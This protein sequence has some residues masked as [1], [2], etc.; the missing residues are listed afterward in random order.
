MRGKLTESNNDYSFILQNF[1]PETIMTILSNHCINS[2]ID[3]LSKNIFLLRD[4][5]P[6]HRAHR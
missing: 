1:P 2:T 3:V 4:I 5:I 6:E